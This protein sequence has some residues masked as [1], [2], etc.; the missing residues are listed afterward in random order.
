M[1][2]EKSNKSKTNVILVN[3]MGYYLSP[4]NVEKSNVNIELS[5][6]D[7]FKEKDKLIKK[8]LSKTNKGLILLHGEKGTGKTYYIRHLTKHINKQFIFI[9]NYLRRSISETNFITFLINNCKNSIIVIEDAEDI[10][11]SRESLNSNSSCNGIS[12]LLNMTDG[13]LSDVLQIQFICTF[14]TNLKNID[15]A[16]L[17][18]G[19]LIEEHCFDKLNYEKS[20]KLAESLGKNLQEKREYALSEI[21]NYK[22][23][24]KEN[25]LN[26]TKQIGF[27]YNN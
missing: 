2:F 18:E 23:D 25:K 15:S 8:K 14:N 26:T 27:S 11:K 7:E 3:Q 19:R 10:I 6:D 12:D 21:Y 9:P 20:L 4:N 5:Y 22:N 13:L 16:L 1:P 24:K 17:R